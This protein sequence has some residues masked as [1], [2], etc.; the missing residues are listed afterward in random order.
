MTT[1]TQGLQLFE[2]SEDGHLKHPKFKDYYG[3]DELDG[4]YADEAEAYEELRRVDHL[5]E[6]FTE[7]TLVLL[8]A[9]KIKGERS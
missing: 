4:F 6:S 8:P 5:V 9:I 1:L 3:D 7:R 2:I